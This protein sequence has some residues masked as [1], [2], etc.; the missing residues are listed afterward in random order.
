MSLD[1]SELEWAVRLSGQLKTLSDLAETLTYRMLEL[2]ERFAGQE[3]QLVS[4]QL[5]GEQR[6][7]DMT[8]AMEERMRETEDRLGQ[9]E[10]LLRKDEQRPSPSPALRALSRPSSIGRRDRFL[11]N[12]PAEDMECLDPPHGDTTFDEDHPFG[13]ESHDASLAS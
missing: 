7:A 2:E 13:A 3:N 9:I 8:Q 12:D 6:H 11:R 10:Q 5:D 4:R 1:A